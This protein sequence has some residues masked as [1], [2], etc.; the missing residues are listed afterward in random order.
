VSGTDTLLAHIEKDGKTNLVVTLENEADGK[1][2]GQP[3]QRKCFICCKYFNADDSVQY[4][5]TSCWCSH[6]HIPLCNVD[7]R[8][9]ELGRELTCEREHITSCSKL[10]GCD[11]YVHEAGFIKTIALR[12]QLNIN[13]RRTGRT[14]QPVSATR[15]RAI[16]S[17]KSSKSSA[18]VRSTPIPTPITSSINLTIN[19]QSSFYPCLFVAPLKW[20]MK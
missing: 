10:F 20:S 12:H 17:S 4:R 6:C 2:V 14:S 9:P 1:K 5:Y 7:R 8:Q 11:G 19:C 15:G 16:A 13:P 3:I 18:L